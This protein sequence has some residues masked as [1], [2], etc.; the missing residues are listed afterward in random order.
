MYRTKCVP[1]QEEE[2]EG[3]G[4]EEEDGRRRKKIGPLKSS[5]NRQYLSATSRK[6]TGLVNKMLEEVYLCKID[7]CLSLDKQRDRPL[8][9]QVL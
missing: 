7:I 3:G 2:E 4:T 8:S 1:K 6:K 9:L 5:E